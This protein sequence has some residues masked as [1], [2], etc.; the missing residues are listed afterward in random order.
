MSRKAVLATLVAVALV[1]GSEA[2]LTAPADVLREGFL[3]P[4]VSARPQV[5]WHWMNGNVSRAGITA[6]LEA[7]A[8]VGIGGAQIF[9]A[10]DDIP[11]GPVAFASE[12]WQSLVRFA[13]QEAKR[14]GLEL[15]IHNCSGWSSSGG[16]WVAPSNA[17]KRVVFTETAVKGGSRF[18][19]KLPAPPD[20]YG[21]Y[22]DIAVLAVKTP[23]AELRRMEDYGV[24]V[25]RRSAE[26]VT[27]RF[28]KAF[29]ASGLSFACPTADPRYADYYVTVRADGECLVD[30]R[31]VCIKVMGD[32]N[33]VGIYVP[34]AHQVSARQIDVKF[35][36][37]GG[38]KGGTRQPKI[39]A[40][41]IESGFRTPDLASKA[42]A[43]RYDSYPRANPP[44]TDDQIVP[45]TDVK[46]LARG[47]AAAETVEWDVPD[48][49]WTLIRFGYACDGA[50][51]RPGSF[52]GV[53]L[54]A[55]KLDARAV[56]AHYREFRR[57]VPSPEEGLTTL[58]VD[59]Y[60]VGCP[61]WTESFE[62][63][64]RKRCGYD[65]VP[66]LVKLTGR[67]VGGVRETEKAL[68]DYRRT[69]ADLFAEN[70]GRRFAE[71]CHRD[72]YLFELEGYGDCPSSDFEYGRW[73]DIPMGEFWAHAGHD[74]LTGN[75]RYAGFVSHVW[76]QRFAASESFT[77]DPRN[78]CWQKDAFGLKR[79]GDC[80]YASGVNRI[81][82]HRYAHQP[83]TNPT[84]YPGM[85]MGPHGTHFERTLTWWEQSAEWLKY[86]AR[87][88]WM[89]QEGTFVADA[90]C[91]CG[92][93]APHCGWTYPLEHWHEYETAKLP[94][95]D[96]YAFDCCAVDALEAAKVEDGQVVVPGGVRYAVLGLPDE[97][98]IGPRARAAIG[99][100]VA[101][102]AKTV[103]HWEL[104]KALAEAVR[105]PDF[106]SDRT[107]ARWIHRRMRD[108]SEF[109]FVAF[110]N[111]N[112]AKATCT[113]RVS[114]KIPEMWCPVTGRHWRANDWREA[115]GLTT[116]R[117]PINPI[118][119]VFIV[120]RPAAIATAPVEPERTLTR[121]T[122]VEG[123]WSVSFPAKFAPNPLAKGTDETVEFPEL[124]SWTE[125]QERDIRYFSG[126]AT[127]RK[128]IA[129]APPK[130]GE[131]LMLDL[132]E[133]KNF[134]DV[135]VNGR[136]YP[137]LW[138]P[139][140]RID[141][142]DILNSSTSQPLN[143]SIRV[144]NLWVNRLIGDDALPVDCEWNGEGRVGL[145]VIP[146]WVLNGESSP[147]GRLTFTTWR[148]WL[149]D[150]QPLASG[151]LGPVK[152]LH[153]TAV[154]IN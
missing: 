6:D 19:G 143:I 108:G 37:K 144:T 115:D 137:T 150:D 4:P 7:M 38:S 130:G 58:I 105:R 24:S 60:E 42:L 31:R 10:S 62:E 44:V 53:G 34:F 20:P 86:Q 51:N 141:I 21:Y 74:S 87:C 123:A 84:R 48:G 111:T 132:G 56:D 131:R 121:E 5:W 100:L 8:K 3:R 2:A 9:D 103:P 29:P 61:N 28:A 76:G 140:F 1:V 46:V 25:S 39:E 110:C 85:T 63:E 52:A 13:A 82:Y 65:I 119:S 106:Q 50:K 55:D 41:R 127:Y 101:A 114:G 92:E 139:P 90:L 142:T 47:K 148:H 59:S 112:A 22:R 91:F 138:K 154:S 40:L 16:P 54:E 77:A 33:R 109:Y 57:L 32:R 120:F 99:R 151:L 64:F 36:Y 17:Q 125:R 14:L 128:T 118:A 122:A 26:D 75:T 145:K 134:A 66:H 95:P 149:K 107:D 113:F 67:I 12:E 146:A 30:G 147:S 70:Y 126:T 79:Q 18:C 72:G 49:A 117:F 102:G 89:L 45:E 98:G 35:A 15:A 135:T 129:C 88:Q 68:A 27:F 43:I 94:V 97:A 96:G 11:A 104:P 73:A 124:V 78:G 133:V 81:V 153:L 23:A 136:P 83:W 80:A 116:V 152:L 93:D 69:V 71:L